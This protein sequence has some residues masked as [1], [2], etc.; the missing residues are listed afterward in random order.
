MGTLILL[1]HHPEALRTVRELNERNR[2]WATGDETGYADLTK[3]LNVQRETHMPAGVRE[4]SFQSKTQADFFP[5]SVKV[6]RLGSYL[7]GHRM[8]SLNVIF[9]YPSWEPEEWYRIPEW[10]TSLTLIRTALSMFGDS[11]NEFR[12]HLEA[13]E[14]MVCW[15]INQEDR[16]SYFLGW[17]Y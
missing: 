7:E 5:T 10:E 8:T 6:D 11:R 14:E 4:I 12:S 15:V 13:F 9:G 16:A 17:S 1:Y 3:A 2:R